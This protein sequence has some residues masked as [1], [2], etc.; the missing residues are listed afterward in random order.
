M[1][2]SVSPANPTTV[3]PESLS[4][5]FTAARDWTV[6]TNQYAGGE[7]QGSIPQ[8]Y[9]PG[10]T[11][12][13][14]PFQSSRRSWQCTKRLTSAQW[15]ALINFWQSVGGCQNEF[16]FYDPYETSPPFSYD[17][18]GQA[19]TGRFAVRFNGDLTISLS[20]GR[21]VQA[22]VSLLEVA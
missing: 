16:W 2:N 12:Q 11:G 1:P 20:M 10:G 4:T 13:T 5:A 22:N 7:Y 18:T 9:D 6:D 17:P 21:P 19:T 8:A 14:T 3:F 15:T